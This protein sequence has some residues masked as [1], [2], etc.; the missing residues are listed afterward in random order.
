MKKLIHKFIIYLGLFFGMFILP[1]KSILPAFAFLD[2][3][4]WRMLFMLIPMWLFLTFLTVHPFIISP[5]KAKTI[6]FI[7]GCISGY[8]LIVHTFIVNKL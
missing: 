8:I 5:S 4:K 6:V 3:K 2:H 7:I 1:P